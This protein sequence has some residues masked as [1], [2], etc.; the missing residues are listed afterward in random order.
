MSKKPLIWQDIMIESE[1][2]KARQVAYEKIVKSKDYEKKYSKEDRDMLEDVLAR[3]KAFDENMNKLKL[4][5]LKL[6]NN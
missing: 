2:N 4:S 3:L 5:K 1:N 6:S